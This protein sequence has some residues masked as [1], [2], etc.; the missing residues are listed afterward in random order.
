MQNREEGK[1]DWGEGDGGGAG[2]TA[3]GLMGSSPLPHPSQR[4][5]L[6]PQNTAVPQ[7]VE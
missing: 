3:W 4:F 7:V 6:I 5:L 1:P 2:K